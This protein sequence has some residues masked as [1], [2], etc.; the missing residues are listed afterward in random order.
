MLRLKPMT[1]HFPSFATVILV[2][3]MAINFSKAKS[4]RSLKTQK[5]L[6][7]DPTL[8]QLSGVAGASL[9]ISLAALQDV[10]LRKTLAFLDKRNNEEDSK[11]RRPMIP[12][13]LTSILLLLKKNKRAEVDFSQIEYFIYHKKCYYVNKYLNKQP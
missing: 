13:P 12:L 6:K 5:R 4:L 3:T 1:S 10:F 2:T 7:K 11:A 8:L 9:E